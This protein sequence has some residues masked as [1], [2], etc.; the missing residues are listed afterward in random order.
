MSAGVADIVEVLAAAKSAGVVSAGVAKV[1]AAAASEGA[2][3]PVVV[4]ASVLLDASKEL[5]FTRV[6]IWAYGIGG[7]LYPAYGP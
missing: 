5:L 2:K 7:K 4:F 3:T 6:G 1:L